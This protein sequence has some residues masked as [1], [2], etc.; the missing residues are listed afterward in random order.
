[1]GTLV[2]KVSI[3]KIYNDSITLNVSDSSWMQ[4]LYLLS[5]LI[6]KKI[7]AALDKPRIETIRFYYAAQKEEKI[8]KTIEEIATPNKEITLTTKEQ[9]A[10]KKISD[11]ELYQALTRLL[12]KCH[13]SS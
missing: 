4:E 8:E 5:S 9:N 3:R 7:N 1:M 13:R 11:P 2:S 6:K 10:L 12:Q